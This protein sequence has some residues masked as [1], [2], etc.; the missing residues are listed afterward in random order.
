VLGSAACV[1]AHIYPDDFCQDIDAEWDGSDIQVQ[2]FC[3]GDI[4]QFTITNN[5]TAMTD[6]SEYRMYEDDVLLAIAKFQL[7]ESEMRTIN[8]PATG[9]TYRLVAEQ[10]TGHP[11]SDSPQAVV[12]LCGQ[13]PFS[14]GFV[15]S[16]A[17]PDIDPFIAIN[18]EEIIGSY[19][20][21]N[22]TVMPEGIGEENMIENDVALEY[23]IHFQNVGNDTAFQ[24]IIVDTLDTQHL[25]INTLEI[26][27]SSHSYSLEMLEASILRFTFHDIMLLDSNTNETASHGFVSYKIEQMTDNELGIVI[28]NEAYIFF[29]YNQP[30]QTETTSNKLWEIPTVFDTISL[31]TVFDKK[32]AIKVYPNPAKAH[33]FVDFSEIKQS[34]ENVEIFVYDVFG[35]LILAQKINDVETHFKV[36]ISDL[37]NGVY[38]YKIVGDTDVL[39]SGKIMVQ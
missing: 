7:V 3:L 34:I 9:K 11:S 14:L 33:F 20:S 26:L 24:V 36:S 27:N 29:D 37:E 28:E 30:I 2:G 38:I 1:S 17:M 39:G 16:Q 8:V 21:N 19:N 32:Q 18:C 6:S 22:K 12:E 10:R 4:V 25:N 35:R 31:V 5:G 13:P 15:T 23:K